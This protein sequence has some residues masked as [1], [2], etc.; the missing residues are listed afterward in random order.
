MPKKA[1]PPRIG[2]DGTDA[3]SGDRKVLVILDEVDKI[4]AN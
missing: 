3:D 1:W 4:D 2:N